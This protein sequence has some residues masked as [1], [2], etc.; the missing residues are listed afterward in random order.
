MRALKAKSKLII[1][2][3]M[4]N[5]SAK[6]GVPKSIQCDN[7]TEFFNKLTEEVVL[8]TDQVHTAIL[9]TMAI[10]EGKLNRL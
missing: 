5:I 4:W 6:F 7:A 1:A 3:T 2:A 10:R 9:I 8:T